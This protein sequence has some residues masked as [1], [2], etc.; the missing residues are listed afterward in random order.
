MPTI[1]AGRMMNPQLH[2][3]VVAHLAPRGLAA[4]NLRMVGAAVNDAIIVTDNKG[5]IVVWNQAAQRIFGYGNAEAQGRKLKDLIVPD[6]YRIDFEKNV[7]QIDG[8]G[9]DSD[10]SMPAEMAGLRKD[11]MEIVTE[12]SMSRVKMEGRWHVIYIV[13]DITARKQAEEHIRERTAALEMLSAKMLSSDEMEKKKLAFG[14][15]EGL[16]QTLVMIK[17]R[18]ERNREAL[19]T[20]QALDDSSAS[21]VSLLQSTINDVEA[22]AT[23]LRPSSLDDIGLLRTI[24]WFCRKF[25]RLHPAIHVLEEISAEEE[26]VPEPLKIVIYRIIES[27]FTNIVRYENTDQIA[28]ALQRED[29]VITLAIDDTSPDSRY[30]ATAE[31]NADRQMRFGEAQ[32]RTILSGGSFTIARGKAGGISL[33]ASWAA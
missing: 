11:G 24:G 3:R 28:L 4:E 22:I 32:E 23:A 20:S 18:V 14:L 16:A 13:R 15:H 5:V 25:D 9:R 2:E 8:N 27:A 29:G 30:A 33:R 17:M 7:T 31:R 10:S 26:D 1:D 12:I 21:I 19:A 6:R